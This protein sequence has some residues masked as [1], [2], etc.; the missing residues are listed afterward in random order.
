MKIFNLNIKE[1]I[2]AS[3]AIGMIA[4]GCEK[5]LDVQPY[6]SMPVER[7]LVTEG[8]VSG[9]LVGA[10]DAASSAAAYGGDMMVLNDLIGNRT[11]INFRGTFAGLV[12][13]W[14]ASMTTNNSFAAST[15][16]AAYNTINVSNNV[17]EN[18]DKI[19]SSTTKKQSA[20]GQAL[21]L[22]ASM[23]FE[24]LKLYSRPY[25][26]GNPAVNLGVPI[27]LTATK[28]PITGSDSKPRA[29]V[30]AVYERIIADL[31]KA[32]SLLPSTNTKFATK[33]AAA[34]QLS[35]VYLAMENY[36]DAADAANRV[37]AGSGKT[38]TLQFKD[39]WFTYVN[40]NG[41]TPNEYVFYIKV[42]NQD[43]TNS[44]N[45]Y[46]GR[47]IAAFPGSAGRSDMRIFT[48]HLNIYESADVRRAFFVIDGSRYTQKHL[49]R[50]GDV[51]VIRL[52]E[53]YLTRAE[54]NFRRNT[55]VGATPLS[56]V[57]M[58][59][60]RAGLADLTSVTLDLDAILNER[61]AELALEGN[62]LFE[63]QR[64][65]K[66]LGTSTSPIAWNSSKLIL[67]IPQREMDVNKE[68][69]QNEAYIIK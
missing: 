4:I 63:S 21:F 54:A 33:W 61:A 50:F 57:N 27:V 45:T 18:L 22:R 56:D 37:I 69:I 14:N 28:A 8:D 30:Q 31:I 47:S 3:I 51:P 38:L 55:A 48:A 12:E 17:L 20:E 15:W 64:L 65:K 67:P 9:T 2:F 39:N 44:L 29:T 24:L 1:S 43:G 26:D 11:N 5:K 59:R 66:S 60:K 7:A 13:A 36:K 62:N 23:Y 58:I 41:V 46:Y 53:M 42:S 34:A 6:Q 35:R 32:E 16:S 19:V 49:D 68:L 10:Y 40:F 52:A 25:N